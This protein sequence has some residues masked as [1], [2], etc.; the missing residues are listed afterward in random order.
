MK[1]YAAIAAT[2]M[3]ST[4]EGFSNSVPISSTSPGWKLGTVGAPIQIRVFY[5]LLC[6]DSKDAHY[7]WKSLLP[8]E[9][10]IKGKKYSD[11][12]DMNVVPFVLPYH[13]HSYQI[14]QVVPYLSDLCA[15]D[16]TKCYFEKYAELSWSQWESILGQKDVSID[17]F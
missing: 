6:P 1:S 11:L 9:S 10:H 16:S 7:I 2:M 12:V 17:D 4:V 15:S 8:Q 13:S 5:D 3:A 14:T